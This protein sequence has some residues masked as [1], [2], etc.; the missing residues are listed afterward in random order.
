MTY[1][2]W[3]NTL[4]IFLTIFETYPTFFYLFLTS[5]PSAYAVTLSSPWA[6]L[7]TIS[8]L[9][10][11]PISPIQSNPILRIPLSGN[12]FVQQHQMLLKN[13]TVITQQHNS[14]QGLSDD[15]QR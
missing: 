5:N 13:L 7:I 1:S 4:L 8:F 6:P 9:Y 12:A 11:C 3:C 10:S 14:S 15:G 2:N